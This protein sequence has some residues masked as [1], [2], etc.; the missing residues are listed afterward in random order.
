MVASLIKMEREV[1]GIVEGAVAKFRA[2]RFTPG[3][4]CDPAVIGIRITRS[5]DRRPGPFHGPFHGWRK[6]AR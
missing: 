3:R 2:I 5:Q 1:S 6:V 4:A